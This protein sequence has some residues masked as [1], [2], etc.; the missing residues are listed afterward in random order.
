MQQEIQQMNNETK[1]VGEKW[2]IEQGCRSFSQPQKSQG[3][4][5]DPTDSELSPFIAHTALRAV[6]ARSRVF[7]ASGG[8]AEADGAFGIRHFILRTVHSGVPDH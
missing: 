5:N 6:G 8:D 3:F 1:L 2:P 7:L 4:G